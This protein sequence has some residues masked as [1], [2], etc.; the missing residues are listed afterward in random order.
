MFICGDCSFILLDAGSH[1]VSQH[2]SNAVGV[3]DIQLFLSA[4][5]AILYIADKT[6]QTE[7]MKPVLLQHCSVQHRI[8]HRGAELLEVGGRMVYSTCSFNPIENEAVIA[9]V[10]Q[11]SAGQ[12]KKRITRFIFSFV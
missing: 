2:S 3:R 8:L 4:S 5:K 11:K 6:A 12:S 1:N 9:S 10:L 7:P